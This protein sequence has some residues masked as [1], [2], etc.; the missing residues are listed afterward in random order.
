MLKPSQN[1][2]LWILAAIAIIAGLLLSLRNAGFYSEQSRLIE[3]KTEALAEIERMRTANSGAEAALRTLEQL[4]DDTGD[5]IQEL[6][7]ATGS[8]AEIEQGKIEKLSAG[9]N[10]RQSSVVFERIGAEALLNLIAALETN[11]PPWRVAGCSLQS[12]PGSAG[13]LRAALMLERV[14]RTQ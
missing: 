3:S 9:W 10:L 11:T 2:I 6:L 4:P 13:V 12:L 1:A 8:A 5:D 14:E 7:D